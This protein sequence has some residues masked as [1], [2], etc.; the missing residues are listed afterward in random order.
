MSGKVNGNA[1]RSIGW[2]GE[3]FFRHRCGQHA[4]AGCGQTQAG[5]QVAHQ[6]GEAADAP[7]ALEAPGVDPCLGQDGA[8]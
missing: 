8:L 6:A 2:R 4:V 5:G 3:Q 1:S 7:V